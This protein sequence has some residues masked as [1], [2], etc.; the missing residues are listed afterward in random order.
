MT[1]DSDSVS[2]A[3]RSHHYKNESEAQATADALN[4]GQCDIDS[5]STYYEG[6]HICINICIN[7]CSFPQTQARSLHVFDR[8]SIQTS[9]LLH[10][11]HTQTSW[12]LH[13]RICHVSGIAP[14]V[15]D[16]LLTN[17]SIDRALFNSMRVRFK[18]GML[19][20]RLI[21]THDPL[22][23]LCVLAK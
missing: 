18:L 16:G 19:H 21:S 15:E 13:A 12:L 4:D 1:S 8:F 10:T 23:A 22:L 3:W 2:D 14:A 9:W 20:P 7:I 11:I 5:G 17:E 6:A